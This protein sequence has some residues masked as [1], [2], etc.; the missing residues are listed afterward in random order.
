LIVNNFQNMKI[1]E[2][3]IILLFLTISCS[4][5][6]LK[7]TEIKNLLQNIKDTDTITIEAK[8]ADC[9][10]WGGHIERFDILRKN[11]NTLS[12]HYSRDTVNC[13]DPS[14][15]NR[16]II[17]EWINKLSDKDQVL[18]INFIHELIDKSFNNEGI[19]NAGNFYSV[20]RNFGH[21]NIGY[22]NYNKDWKGFENLKNSLKNP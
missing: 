1:L 10:E 21:L 14:C 15:F 13:P 5:T 12:V 9:G 3:L 17:E 2:L 6:P 7:N 16:R 8:F 22:I 19:S 11:D 18:I 4:K 20:K